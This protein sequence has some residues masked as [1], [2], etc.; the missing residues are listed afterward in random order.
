M[1]RISGLPAFL[2]A[3]IREKLDVIM[4]RNLFTDATDAIRYCIDMVW[5]E[6]V[7]QFLNDDG[8]EK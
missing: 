8:D 1:K 4:K 2:G 3:E 6:Q 7:G 5:F